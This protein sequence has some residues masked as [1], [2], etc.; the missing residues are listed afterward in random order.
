[1]DGV[2]P[3]TA[4]LLDAMLVRSIEFV[5]A[6]FSFLTKEYETLKLYFSNG[7]K[8]W[9][10]L[11]NFVKQVFSSEFHVVRSVSRSAD[12]A[13]QEGTNE[14]VIWTALRTISIQEDFLR[15]IIQAYPVLTPDLC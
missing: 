11:C 10:F 8:C 15:K 6:V 3:A 2:E 14:K 12:Y 7:E 9:N 1:M 5:K 4:V 13:D